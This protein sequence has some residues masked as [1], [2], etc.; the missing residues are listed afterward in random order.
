MLAKTC[1]AQGPRS[2]KGASVV[3]RGQ[4]PLP[5]NCLGEYFRNPEPN[6]DGW[7]GTRLDCDRPEQ[8]RSTPFCDA[9]VFFFSLSF[10]YSFFTLFF[11]AYVVRMHSSSLPPSA[12]WTRP[13][14]SGDGRTQRI[15]SAICGG[16]SAAAMH[17]ACILTSR[18]LS[19]VF[20]RCCLRPQ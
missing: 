5:R 11:S 15:G 4:V 9:I 7:A 19:P 8:P 18:L 13:R 20:V 6:G 17:S 16:W 1:P 2:L 10:V 12:V 3:R 14:R